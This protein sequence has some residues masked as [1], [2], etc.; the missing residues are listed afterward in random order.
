V[1]K[2]GE[3]ALKKQSS[4]SL[5]TVRRNS[6]LDPG[7]AQ[8]EKEKKRDIYRGKLLGTRGTQRKGRLTP[9]EPLDA[10]KRRGTSK[11]GCS[12]HHVEMENAGDQEIRNQRRL[13]ERP[14]QRKILPQAV[15]P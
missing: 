6:P 10:R 9:G 7:R 2:H 15:T 4:I 12:K 5:G 3:H 1:K 13:R 8:C 14:I 11:E